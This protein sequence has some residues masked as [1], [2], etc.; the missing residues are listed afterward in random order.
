MTSE[1]IGKGDDAGI[2]KYTEYPETP[3]RRVIDVNHGNISVAYDYRWLEDRSSTEVKK[4][5][6]EQNRFTRKYPDS[7][8]SRAR[9]YDRLKELYSSV[10]PTYYSGIFRAGNLLM[11]KRDFIR[12]QPYLTEF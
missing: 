9:I 2:M 7:I 1:I 3:I 6:D 10:S 11:M 5:I 4:W 8:R 12:Q